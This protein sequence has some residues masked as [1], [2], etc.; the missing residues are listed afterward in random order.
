[1]ITVEREYD[2]FDQFWM[3]KE[4]GLQLCLCKQD[5]CAQCTGKIKLLFVPLLEREQVPSSAHISRIQ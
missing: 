1:M 3:G 2:F 5:M 4:T